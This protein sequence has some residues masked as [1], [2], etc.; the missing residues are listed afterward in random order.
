MTTHAA[1]RQRRSLGGRSPCGE[2]TLIGSTAEPVGDPS[3]SGGKGERYAPAMSSTPGQRAVDA[4]LV[5]VPE[6]QQSTLRAVRAHL[7]KV[8]PR[9]EEGMKYR[10]PSFLVGGAGVAAYAAFKAHCSFFPFSGSV[11]AAVGRLPASTSSS[12]GALRFPADK[13]LS[14]GVVRKLIRARLAELSR[15]RGG[16]RRDYYD[17]GSLKAEGGWRDDRLHGKWRWYRQ[18]GT[19]MR[20]GAFKAGVQVGT[21]QTWARDGRLVKTTVF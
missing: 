14:L 13:P 1:G 21:W 12:K 3:S 2:R 5:G 17:D 8:L 9:A 4:Y 16:K 7:R 18:D 10:M 15:P 19:L 11:L 20:S 6:P